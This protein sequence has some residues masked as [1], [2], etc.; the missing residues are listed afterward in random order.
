MPEMPRATTLSRRNRV[1]LGG[2]A[3]AL[4]LGAASVGV[5]RQFAVGLGPLD[6]SVAQEGSAIVTDRNGRLL[7][8]FTTTDGRWKL[9]VALG[10]VDHSFLALL[11]AYEDQRFEQHSGIDW[12]AMGRAAWQ[13][14]RHGRVVSGG[15]TLTMQ[16]A[17]L[18]EPRENRTL[19]AKARQMVRARQIEQGRTKAQVLDLYLALAPYGGNIEGVRAASLAYFGK[20]PKRLS[21]AESAL[22]VA[23]PQ[24]PEARR[25]DRHPEAARRAR[26]RVLELAVARGAIASDDAEAARGDPIPAQRKA[27]PMMAPHA[28]EQ[29]LRERPELRIQRLSL[30]YRMQSALEALARERLE[31]LPAR[32]SLAML[33][34][35]NLT[36][37]VRAHVG[38]PDYFDAGRAGTVDLAQAVR[39]PGSALKPFIYAMAFEAGI[40]HPETM[41]DDRPSRFASYAPENFDLSYQGNVTAR[42]ALQNSLNVPAVDLLSEVGPTRFI[43]RLR[44]AGAEIALPKDA[45]PGLALALGGL[46]TRLSD[47]A[48]L[49]GGL[50]RGGSTTPLVWRTRVLAA[51]ASEQR[52]TT[53]VAAWYVA[54]ILRGAPPPSNALPGRIAFKTGTSYG[55]RDAW[56]VGFDRRV[57][58]AV[59]IGRPD[60]VPVPGLVGRT[61]AAPVLFDAFARIGA[62]YEPIPV[63]AD[64]LIT[65]TANLPP[66][67]RHMRKDAPKTMAAALTPAL[68]I[69]FPPDGARIDLGLKPGQDK[70][71]LVLKAQGGQTPLIWLVNGRPVTAGDFRRQAS[72]APDGAGFA[73]VSVMDATGATDTVHV[74]LE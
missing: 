58:V 4:G 38:G 26:D 57:T 36:G 11:K 18:L 10:D 39:S 74:R 71:D 40:A 63:P 62:D 3:V 5:V 14:A 15:S 73:R 42:Y 28:A 24:S 35:D 67:L 52:L 48:V 49:Y 13:M 72:W 33:V 32:T 7:R 56:S 46:G 37:E 31:T 68:K 65:R 50:A 47:L 60:G 44:A 51:R 43:G 21:L 20:E 61:H 34:V 70:S 25:P 1:V 19:E 54:D 6:V 8:P 2:A 66:P 53:P 27:F 55:Y 9:P 29:A 69:A 59:W 64:A 23:L 41:V 45:Q 22:L 12:R 30:D 17:R 16:V